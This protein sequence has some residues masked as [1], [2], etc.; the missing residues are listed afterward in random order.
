MT[1]AAVPPYRT[2]TIRPPGLAPLHVVLLCSYCGGTSRAL[3]VC[4]RPG[5][6]FGPVC[7]RCW[8]RRPGLARGHRYQWFAASECEPAAG[9]GGRE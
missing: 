6:A 9:A 7:R 3:G 8:E 4:V 2:A 5:K 1:V